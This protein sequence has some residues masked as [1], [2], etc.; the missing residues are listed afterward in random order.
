MDRDASQ[1]PDASSSSEAATPGSADVIRCRRALHRAASQIASGGVRVARQPFRLLHG[2]D[3]ALRVSPRSPYPRECHT[4]P[5]QHLELSRLL[6]HLDAQQQFAFRGVQIVALVEE[7]AQPDAHASDGGHQR[8][9]PL[10][11]E[12]QGLP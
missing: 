7:F 6:R 8:G 11:R 1:T 4:P 3:G 5:D 10:Y 9:P 2:L 12:P